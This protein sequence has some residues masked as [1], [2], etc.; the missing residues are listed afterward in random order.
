MVPVGR[1]LLDWIILAEVLNP[2]IDLFLFSLEAPVYFGIDDSTLLFL[3][4]IGYSLILFFG[5]FEE[6]F[7][8]VGIM[9]KSSFFNSSTCFLYCFFSSL[10]LSFLR[11]AN[12]F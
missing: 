11:L 10:S 6:P 1:E 7:S 8:L 3:K 9:S 4:K 5:F 2:S 12:I